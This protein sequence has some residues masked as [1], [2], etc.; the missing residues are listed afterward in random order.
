MNIK[1]ER[2]DYV[3]VVNRTITFVLDGDFCCRVSYTYKT[4]Q[5]ALTMLMRFIKEY[6]LKSVSGSNGRQYILREV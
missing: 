1:R 3:D 4:K 2:I 5:I 6:D